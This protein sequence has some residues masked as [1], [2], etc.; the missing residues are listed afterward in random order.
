[1]N[2][3]SVFI[4]SLATSYSTL[5]ATTA[6][7]FIT[8][9]ITVKYFG[10]N[11]YGLWALVSSLIAY[12][13]L[14]N[15]GIPFTSGVL[16][17]TL[18][19]SYEKFLVLKKSFIFLVII[20]SISLIVFLSITIFYSDW[21]N[22]I[23]KMPKELCST[24]KKVTLLMF[25]FY[26]IKSPLSIVFDAFNAFQELYLVKIYQFLMV[27]INFICLLITVYTNQNL[28]FLIYATNISVISITLI[29]IIHFF[30][31]HKKILITAF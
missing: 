29:A 11:Q 25:I 23:G 10:N 1:M 6:I 30:I 2:S 3:K 24:A 9:P 14:I 16:I 27:L 21:I 15:F 5:I 20:S 26:F 22:F 31:K 18:S 7:S 4:K 12:L 13:N 28:L 8:L 19:N 17:A